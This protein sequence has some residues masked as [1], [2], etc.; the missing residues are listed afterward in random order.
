[1]IQL[2]L[3]NRYWKAGV[4]T[5]VRFKESAIFE[6]EEGVLEE[7]IENAKLLPI[8]ALKVK[9]QTSRDLKF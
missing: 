7:V 8:V 3:Y 9:F 6:E 4:V 1:M 2:I 5:S